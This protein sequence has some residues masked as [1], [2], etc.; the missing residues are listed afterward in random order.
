MTHRFFQ[1]F[2]MFTLLAA[3]VGPV[4]GAEPEKAEEKAAGA[5]AEPANGQFKPIKAQ[6]AARDLIAEAQKELRGLK[7]FPRKASDYAHKTGT[8][9][10]G[11][12]VIDALGRRWHRTPPI[13]GYVKWQLLSYQPNLVD[14]EP[15]QLEAIIKNLPDLMPRPKPTAQQARV[16]AAA[17]KQALPRY[18]DKIKEM[19]ADFERSV[20]E[21]H[22]LNE[23]ALTYRDKVTQEMPSAGGLKLMALYFDAAS[24]FDAGEKSHLK[25]VDKMVREAR[26]LKDDTETLPLPVRRKLL[27]LLEAQKKKKNNALDAINMMASGQVN[28]VTVGTFYDH[29]DYSRLTAYL[30]GREPDH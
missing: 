6:E 25:V 29:R 27:A 3:M 4:A 26:Q 7:T 12:E 8:M 10:E 13:D 19:I 14:A 2:L 21:T 30:E 16:F 11:P 24:R 22:G 9:I 23:P 17:E 1:S 15:R 18:K 5:A 20:A 28:L